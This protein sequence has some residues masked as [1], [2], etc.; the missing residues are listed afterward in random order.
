MI[1]IS[2]LYRLLT[3]KVHNVFVQNR[4][5]DNELLEQLTIMAPDEL[6]FW[7]VPLH[8]RSRMLYAESEILWKT[9]QSDYNN[10]GVTANV[11]FVIEQFSV[12]YCMDHFSSR[13]RIIVD[14]MCKYCR[15]LLGSIGI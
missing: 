12:E 7:L 8:L 14:P 4:Q 13:Y 1:M 11:G 3:V 5:H 2:I 9:L 15:F 6:D 10:P